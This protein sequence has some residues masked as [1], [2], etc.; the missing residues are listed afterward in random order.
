MRE[1]N[2]MFVASVEN[3]VVLN[4]QEVGKN[5]KV[6]GE[7]EIVEGDSGKNVMMFD[8]G[9]RDKCAKSAG[10]EGQ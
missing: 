1:R 9:E 7:Q 6:I 3:V 4:E 5:E 2:K 8:T 10:D